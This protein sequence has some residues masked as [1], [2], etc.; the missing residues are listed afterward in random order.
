MMTIGQE[1]EDDFSGLQL[2]K[3]TKKLVENGADVVA[4][5]LGKIMTL[6]LNSIIKGDII[7][8]SVENTFQ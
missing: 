5:K 4:K 3:C 1:N 8:N 7:Q 6:L 2:N